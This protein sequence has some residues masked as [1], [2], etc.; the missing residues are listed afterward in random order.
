MEVYLDFIIIG[1]L[2]L[3]TLISIFAERYFAQKGENKAKKEDSQ[4]IQYKIKKGEN[5][6][7]KEDIEEI[8][9]QIET[10]KSE[11]SFE[12]NA[13]MILSIKELRDYWRFFI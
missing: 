3:S 2:V 5:L 4:E 13:D 9:K 12:K 11:I 6:A 10:V 7:I 8:T 1:L